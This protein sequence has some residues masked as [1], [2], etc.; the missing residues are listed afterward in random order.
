MLERELQDAVIDMAHLFGWMVH[1]CRPA[2]NKRGE[3][4]TPIQGDAGFVDL[5]LAS[6]GRRSLCVELKS[7]RGRTT[8]AQDAWKR[9][10][11]REQYRLWRPEDW[12][13]G[14]IENALRG[15]VPSG[16]KPAR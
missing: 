1:H 5:V 14:T 15:L 16:L 9:A 8:S 2:Q 10:I 12:K 11:G 4:S 7:E 6:D 13:D 3:W